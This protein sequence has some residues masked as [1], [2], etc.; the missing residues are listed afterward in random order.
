MNP[1]LIVLI[2]LGSLAVVGIGAWCAVGVMIL[3][4]RSVYPER[5]VSPMP[6][7]VLQAGGIDVRFPSASDDAMLSGWFVRRRR[8][9][10]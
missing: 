3:L 10:A 7:S 6:S 2:V 5:V 9:I 8:A 1:I 4:R